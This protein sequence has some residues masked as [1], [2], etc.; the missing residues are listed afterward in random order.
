MADEKRKR[1]SRRKKGKKGRDYIY[2]LVINKQKGTY[3][4]YKDANTPAKDTDPNH[5]LD[6]CFHAFE[7][8]VT[9][10]TGQAR[11]GAGSGVHIQIPEI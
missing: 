6:T 5:E 9:K 2:T 1:T 11:A 7:E 10:V 3:Q 4:L 8:I